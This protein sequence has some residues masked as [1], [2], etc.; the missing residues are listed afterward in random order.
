MTLLRIVTI[1]EPRVKQSCSTSSCSPIKQEANTLQKEQQF[2]ILPPCTALP[3]LSLSSPSISKV[4][5]T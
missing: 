1:I 2:D 3:Y 4:S 5:L